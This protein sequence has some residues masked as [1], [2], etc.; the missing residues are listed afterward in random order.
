MATFLA[1]DGTALHAKMA[2]PPDALPL[3]LIHGFSMSAGAFARQLDGPL[4]KRF[5][6]I[7]P[8]LRGHGGSAAGPDLRALG[9]SATWASDLAAAVEAFT[10]RP[11][12]V[13]GWSF[14]GRVLCAYLAAGGAA[15]GVI[16]IGAVWDDV[17]PDGTAPHG[18]GASLLPAMMSDDQATAEEA[19]A[20]FIDTMPSKPFV[21]ADRAYLLSDALAVPVKV[22]RAMRALRSDNR[23]LLG[24]LAVPVLALHGGSD[25]VIRPA[26]A[27][28]VAQMAPTG[29][30]TLMPGIGHAPFL[31]DPDAFDQHVIAFADALGG[32]TSSG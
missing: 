22:R 32:R 2:G 3:V 26:A 17:L 13:A 16:F 9:E 31:E 14:G 6:I 11:P 8:D 15:A 24:E 30:L 20:A 5:R 1:R 4:A 21:P 12:I 29:S 18:P 27:A 25:T 19:T 23:R 7:A 28:A 10:T